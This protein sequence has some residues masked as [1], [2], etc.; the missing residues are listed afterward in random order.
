MK[1]TR[2]KLRYGPWSLTP[3]TNMTSQNLDARSADNS[4]EAGVKVA[5]DG[6]SLTATATN[7]N[8]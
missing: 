4:P 7:R 1:T 5:A 8:K 3:C 6:A 2:Q